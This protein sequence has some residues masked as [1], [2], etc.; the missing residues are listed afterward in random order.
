MICII[1][2]KPQLAENTGMAMR[3]MV[4]TGMKN[5]R[6]ISPVHE[7]P[8]KQA[9]LASAEKDYLLNIEKFESLEEAIA[10]LQIV[11]ATSARR[12]DMIKQIFS[13]KSAAEKISQDIGIVFGNERNGLTNEEISLCNF[14]IEIPSVDFS[15]YNLAQSV[16]IVCYEIMISHRSLQNEFHTGKT[17]IANQNEVDNFLKNLEAELSQRNHFPSDKK[18]TLMMQTLKNLFKRAVL[19]SQEIQSMLGVVNTL[20]NKARN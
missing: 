6:I 13:P 17:K 5:L 19:T 16:L 3:A 15:S 2:N 20:A 7:W 10:D 11:F 8:S 14:V 18:H 9:S 4:N 1:L 12:R